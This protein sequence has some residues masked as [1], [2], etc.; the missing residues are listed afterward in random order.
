MQNFF[1][2][3]LRFFFKLLL[4]AFGLVFAVSL[5]AA[6]L[7]M[8]LFGLVKWAV[9]GKKPA[10][11]VAF[12]HFKQFKSGQFAPFSNRSAARTAPAADVVDVEVR[13][14]E[15]QQRELNDVKLPR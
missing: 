4:A 7:V 8:L 15:P 5:L 11:V 10:P 14:V 3:L 12:G 2:Q 13:E 1:G 9:T 6:A